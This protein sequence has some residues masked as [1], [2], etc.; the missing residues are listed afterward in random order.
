MLRFTTSPYDAHRNSGAYRVIST[1]IF[2]FDGLIVDTETPDYVAWQEVYTTHG[3]ALPPETWAINVGSGHLFDPYAHLE[4][5]LGRTVDRETIREQ[6][7]AR[8]RAELGTITTL[9]GVASYLTT[10]QELGL[11]VGLASSSSRAWVAGHLEQV[12]LLGHFE[13][14]CT[15]DDV[16]RTKPE[17]DLYLLALSR[18]S[19]ESAQALALEDSPN[20]VRAAQAAGMRCV[21]VP[22]PVTRLMNLDHADMVLPSLADLPLPALLARLAYS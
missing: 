20:G 21:A 9:P 2:D 8:F 15:S 19:V 10:A 5:Q 12:G 13:A 17:P 4:A 18:L 14:I 1:L 7:R 3:V 16:A 11:R 22:N 6:V